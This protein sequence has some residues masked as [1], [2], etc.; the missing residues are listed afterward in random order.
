MLSEAVLAFFH[1]RAAV[2]VVGTL[3]TRLKHLLHT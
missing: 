1:G 3:L 2:G